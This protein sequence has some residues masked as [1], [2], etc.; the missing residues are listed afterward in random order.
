MINTNAFFDKC[1]RTPRAQWQWCIR[2]VMF[3]NAV[4]HTTRLLAH[5]RHGTTTEWVAAAPPAPV[6]AVHRLWDAWLDNELLVLKQKLMN[7]QIEETTYERRRQLLE[8]RWSTN[9]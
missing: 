7:N 4:Q 8:H 6:V 3:H 9:V 1:Y 2:K 5:R